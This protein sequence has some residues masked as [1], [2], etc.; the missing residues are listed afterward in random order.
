MNNGEAN[1]INVVC[2][3]VLGQPAYKYGGSFDSAPVTDDQLRSALEVLARAANKHLQAGFS[4]AR[5]RELWDARPSPADS[6]GYRAGYDRIRRALGL[7]EGA[8]PEE[9]EESVETAIER[10]GLVRS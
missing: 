2:R 5:V 8:T 4:D 9:I 7:P 1:A 10:L 6:A 3:H